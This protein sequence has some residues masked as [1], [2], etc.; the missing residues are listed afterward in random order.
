MPQKRNNQPPT[1]EGKKQSP[2]KGKSGE[3]LKRSTVTQ[4][5]NPQQ[6]I[7]GDAEERALRDN[8]SQRKDNPNR[9]KAGR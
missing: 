8:P 3:L 7:S 4:A 5:S 6:N 1:G 2:V 9:Q